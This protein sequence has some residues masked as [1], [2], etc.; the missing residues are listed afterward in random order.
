MRVL[1]A[2]SGSEQPVTYME[3]FFD[4][5]F[6]FAVTQLSHYLLGHLT[7][8]GAAQ[9]LLLLLVVWWAWIYTTWMTNWFDPDS[10]PVRVVLLAGM[11]ASLVMAIAI[12]GAFGDRA[13]AFAGGYVALQ[14]IRN[15]FIVL[16]TRPESPLHVSFRRILAWS[17]WTGVI[18]IVG[19]LLEGEARTLV[20]ILALVCDYAGPF[21]GYWTPG[22]GRT[23]TTDWEL[24]HAHFA[25][26]FQLFVI[27]ALGESIVLTGAS[28]SDQQLTAA[29]W[30]A[31]GLGFALSA[32]LWW[33]Y[34]D[35][36]AGRSAADFEAAADERGR[37]G[38]DAFTYL[39]LPIIAGIIA[40]AVALELVI[41]DPRE[42]LGSAGLIV[43]AAG[44]V[45]YLLGH[46]GFRLRM[47]GS[48]SRKRVAA[49]A[50]VVVA[51]LVT[52]AAAALVSLAAVVLVLAA[53]CLSETAGSLRSA[54]VK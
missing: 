44:P 10:V 40:A 14:L 26:R 46:V 35:E 20:W 33:L 1:R 34:F 16:A 42:P 19:A 22:L 36:V 2:A 27:I 45:L 7:V 4:L 52:S 41:A 37:L 38:R 39:H 50:A 23:A 24:E 31:L 29:S 11:L 21:A 6:V 25:E 47:I 48:F 18:W 30:L 32:A 12:P 53:L 3:L 54:V 17:A 13:L 49:I 9:T 5:V 51:V 15:A 28:V 43:L 8:K